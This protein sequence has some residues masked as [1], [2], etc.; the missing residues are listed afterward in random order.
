MN[1]PHGGT[2]RSWWPGARPAH[3]IALEPLWLTWA[4]GS[5]FSIGPGCASDLSLSH[6][7]RWSPF[8][9]PCHQLDGGVV[10]RVRSQLMRMGHTARWD[11]AGGHGSEA[12]A[13]Y[14]L[15]ITGTAEAHV[16]NGRPLA[17]PGRRCTTRHR[18]SPGATAPG[19]RT[20][21]RANS[22]SGRA[23]PGR[24]SGI[25]EGGG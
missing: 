9:Q 12:V 21:R 10:G 7:C 2:S 3:L 15:T 16:L 1:R 14:C 8:K 6:R 11:V 13:A 19:V 22:L 18:Y 20:A 23:S 4:T 25:S 5:A 17:T 24:S